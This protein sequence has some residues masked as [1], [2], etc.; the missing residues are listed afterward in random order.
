[1]KENAELGQVDEAA[2]RKRIRR[3]AIVFAL[4]ALAFYFGFIV[5]TLIRGS[6]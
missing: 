4:I 6:K 5:I 3:T 1:V 2:R